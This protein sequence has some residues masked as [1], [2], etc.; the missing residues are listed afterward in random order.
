M[1]CL[2]GNGHGDEVKFIVLFLILNI[3]LH[4]S[5]V[6]RLKFKLSG[7]REVNNKNK[8]KGVWYAR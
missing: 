2:S 7:N 1:I 8:G 3:K 5:A 4:M 6:R